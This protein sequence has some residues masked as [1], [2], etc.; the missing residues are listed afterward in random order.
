MIFRLANWTVMGI[1]IFY[2]AEGTGMVERGKYFPTLPRLEASASDPAAWFGAAQWGVSALASRAEDRGVNVPSFARE[3]N[4]APA[5]S[6]GR[7]PQ[8]ERLGGF[9]QDTGNTLRRMAGYYGG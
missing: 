8:I 4:A 7:N 5:S 6:Y 2:M 3:A 9:A 1:A